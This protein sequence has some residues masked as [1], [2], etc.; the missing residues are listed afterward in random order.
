MLVRSQKFRE[1][2]LTPTIQPVATADRPRDALLDDDVAV[3][4]LKSESLTQARVS[5]L[6]RD[7]RG[8]RGRMCRASGT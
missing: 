2:F 5:R 6:M 1:Q 3:T 7:G 4:V 8:M